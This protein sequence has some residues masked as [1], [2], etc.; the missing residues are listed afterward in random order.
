VADLEHKNV[1][2]G[3]P[4]D[5]HIYT[6]GGV[7]GGLNWAYGGRGDDRLRADLE[8]RD[9]LVGGPGHEVV[10]LVLDGRPDVVRLRGGGADVLRCSD[11]EGTHVEGEPHDRVF[12]DSTDR[13]DP[14]CK[15]T[16]VLLEGRP[17]LRR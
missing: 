3:G 17:S 14:D 9:M 6:F 8:G 1:A 7:V 12:A 10:E 4:G 16:Q 15:G 2:R 5:D 11:E 13:I